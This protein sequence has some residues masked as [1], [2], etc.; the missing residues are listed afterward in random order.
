[1]IYPDDYRIFKIIENEEQNAKIF[2]YRKSKCIFSGKIQNISP[3]KFERLKI[4]L[5]ELVR[6]NNNSGISLKFGII[7]VQDLLEGFK[8]TLEFFYFENNYERKIINQFNDM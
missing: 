7:E 5:E 4:F 8:W 1:M 6:I 2:L 3:E